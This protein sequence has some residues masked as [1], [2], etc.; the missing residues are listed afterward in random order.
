MNERKELSLIGDSRVLYAF[1]DENEV[2]IKPN[3]ELR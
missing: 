1:R 2:S 3:Y